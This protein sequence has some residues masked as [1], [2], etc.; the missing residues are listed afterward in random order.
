MISSES[1][2]YFSIS[3]GGEY[4]AHLFST[5]ERPRFYR[6]IRMLSNSSSDDSSA[7]ENQ[8]QASTTGHVLTDKVR[9]NNETS[10]GKLIYF[11]IYNLTYSFNVPP[12][13]ITIKPI[14]RN[15]RSGLSY[16]SVGQIDHNN[17]KENALSQS[18]RIKLHRKKFS[19]MVIE[20]PQDSAERHLASDDETITVLPSTSSEPATH[21]TDDE[22]IKLIRTV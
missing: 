18:K 2:T 6:R 9:V 13:S 14:K 20:K 1:E 19:S 11:K 3:D 10:E 16:D 5:P 4:S 21:D 7:P 12:E 22:N 8:Q 17:H 15:R